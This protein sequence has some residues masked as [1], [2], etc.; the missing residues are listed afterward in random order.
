[1]KNNVSVDKIQKIK[2]VFAQRLK[3]LRTK[4]RLTQEELAF[5][6]DMSRTHIASLETASSLPSLKVI[7]KIVDHFNCSFDFLLNETITAD[8][9]ATSTN[10]IFDI[11]KSVDNVHFDDIEV[12]EEEKDIIISAIKHALSIVKLSEKK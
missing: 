3:Y 8:Q 4:N 2:K 5:L 9:Y 12:S 1:M 10:N 11:L 7:I 6:L